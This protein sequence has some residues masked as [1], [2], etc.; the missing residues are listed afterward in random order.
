MKAHYTKLILS[1]YKVRISQL[2]NT[3]MDLFL[4]VNSLSSKEV[5]VSKLPTIQ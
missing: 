1:Y 4:K 5:K 3:G 2:W